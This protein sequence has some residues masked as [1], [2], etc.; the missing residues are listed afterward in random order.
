MNIQNR[1]KVGHD[2]FTIVKMPSPD[3]ALDYVCDVTATP[4][5][6]QYSTYFKHEENVTYETLSGSIFLEVNG[7]GFT[8]PKGG[9]VD[10]P[11]GCQYR[12][13]GTEF[14]PVR[15][16]LYF[17]SSCIWTD[18]QN[19]ATQVQSRAVSIPGGRVEYR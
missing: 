19:V 17:S 8:L 14:Q 2:S 11:A 3:S 9:I 15:L 12:F 10:I 6:H 1:I 18:L 13:H 4:R 5:S 7:H 16:R